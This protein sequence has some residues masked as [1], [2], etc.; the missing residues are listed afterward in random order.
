MPLL[1]RRCGPVFN[2]LSAAQ[3]QGNQGCCTRSQED[4]RATGCA[5]RHAGRLHR[6]WGGSPECH[7]RTL[8][9]S[10]PRK[11]SHDMAHFTLCCQPN[12]QFGVLAI[13][14][15]VIS[16][17]RPHNH[18]PLLRRCQVPIPLLRNMVGNTSVVR[19]H[20]PIGLAFVEAE[21]REE[22]DEGLK[23]LVSQ[24]ESSS[25]LASNAAVNEI[26]KTYKNLHLSLR[27]ET[28]RLLVIQS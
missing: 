6:G 23:N 3:E 5:E 2:R 19:R 20:F 26:R 9:R 18:H 22:G 24:F 12:P 15:E 4:W 14:D 11:C 8:G 16:P 10:R 25:K 28:T 7:K 13:V 21:Q 27:F 17:G 1:G